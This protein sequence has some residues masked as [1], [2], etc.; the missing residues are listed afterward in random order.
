MSRRFLAFKVKGEASEV[1]KEVITYLNNSYLRAESSLGFLN[2][3]ASI[4]GEN[5]KVLCSG[6][7]N[8]LFRSLDS[9]GAEDKYLEM[10][11]NLLEMRRVRLENLD[12]IKSLIASQD[13]LKFY[14]DHEELIGHMGGYCKVD[15]SMFSEQELWEGAIGVRILCFT[16]GTE[17]VLAGAVA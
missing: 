1:V 5:F 8:Y 3:L 7:F 15:D 11:R 9:R 10:V 12:L 6:D 4:T 16:N 2:A 14:F 13:R 17:I